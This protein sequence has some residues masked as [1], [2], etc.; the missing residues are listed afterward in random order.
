MKSLFI[1]HLSSGGLITNYFCTSTCRHC[2]YR[3]SPKWPKDYISRDMARKNLEIIRSLGC[4]SIHIGGGEPLLRFE[5]LLQVLDEAKSCGV[6]IEY[7]ETNSSWYRGRSEACSVLRTLRKH[8]VHTLLVSISPFHSEY[9]PFSRV[10]GVIEACIETGMSVFPWV[11]G[12]VPDLSALDLDKPHSMEE[13]V[14]RFGKD[15]LCRIQ[16]RYWISPGG[17]ALETFRRCNP[18]K[19]VDEICRQAGPGCPE[20]A[21][22]SH[23][24]LDLYGNYVPGLC[25]GLA[26]ARKDLGAPLDPGRY[27][28]LT[29][30]YTQGIGALLSWAAEKY[31]F[32]PGKRCYWTKCELCH[33]IRRYMVVQ[34]GVNT[35]E[36]QPKYHY[37]LG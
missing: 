7:V 5:G 18:L 24:H 37:T 11:E 9:I 33:E 28:I 36:L 27:P 22:T 3:C 29:M 26:I 34:S 35:L 10:K 14:E 32:S 25:A 6:A 21:D 30:L 13:F 8:G 19:S 23:F 31:G 16:K 1:K 2:L 15:Y 17:R 4:S 12:F 20:L